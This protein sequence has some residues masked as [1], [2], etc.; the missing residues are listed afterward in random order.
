MAWLYVKVFG[1]HV[2]VTR[3]L[4]LLKTVFWAV[5]ILVV[6]ETLVLRYKESFLAR[7]EHFSYWFDTNWAIW[8]YE[9]FLRVRGAVQGDDD[10]VCYTSNGS[11]FGLDLYFRIQ[12]GQLENI[13]VLINSNMALNSWF[14]K[15]YSQSTNTAL[16]M[17]ESGLGT[18]KKVL[19]LITVLTLSLRRLMIIN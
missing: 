8:P 9:A 10:A 1:I 19:A 6:C 5:S 18:G 16:R 11:K 14:L 17:V 4:S 15:I 12:K 7:G 3:L 13:T 2:L